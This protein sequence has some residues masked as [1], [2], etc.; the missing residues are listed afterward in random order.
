MQGVGAMTTA[1][2]LTRATTR[3]DLSQL[4]GLVGA[5]AFILLVVI[6]IIPR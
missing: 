6:S 2:T 1:A 4:I 5:L 3:N